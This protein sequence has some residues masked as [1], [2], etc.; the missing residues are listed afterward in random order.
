MLRHRDQILP[1]DHARLLTHGS[2]LGLATLLVPLSLSSA[3][4][5]AVATQ[6]QPRLNL[7]G[8]AIYNAGERSARL[9]Y[10]LP[11]SA[12]GSPALLGLLDELSSQAGALGATSILA[13]VAPDDPAF[14]SMRRCGFSV[15]AW[16]H[17]WQFPPAAA[18][19]GASSR[20]ESARSLDEFA[21]RGLFAALVPPLVQ[22]AEPFNPARS[23][24]V[25][26]QRGDLLAYA[27]Q[28]VGPRGVYLQ[29]IIHPDVEDAPAL[30]AS[31][32]EQMPTGRPLYLALRSYQAWLT[33]ALEQLGGQ[34]S[35]RQAL[36]VKHLAL[37][38]RAAV[39]AVRRAVLEQRGEPTAPIINQAERR[40]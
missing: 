17:I 26:R 13:E 27:A 35:P 37:T 28:T 16:Q 30:M 40:D 8:Q 33:P 12:S 38:Q 36:L 20:W 32:L 31:L 11:A 6:T 22:S 5:T 2:P 18:G 21:V 1:L 25:Y 10:M 24:Y 9:E 23:G 15:F 14:E 39:P 3:S 29:P 19:N 34:P 4:Y 7:I